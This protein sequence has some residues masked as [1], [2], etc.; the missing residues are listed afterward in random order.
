MGMV[1][2]IKVVMVMMVITE[3]VMVTRSSS[4]GHQIKEDGVLVM[5]C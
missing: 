4:R 2:I 3:M 5:K 1:M